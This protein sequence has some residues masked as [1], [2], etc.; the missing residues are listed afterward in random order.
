MLAKLKGHILEIVTIIYA[1]ALPYL[2]AKFG[3][4]HTTNSMHGIQAMCL[5]LLAALWHKGVIQA[6]VEA[7]LSGPPGKD[8][9]NTSSFTSTSTSK[10]A[11]PATK[12][13]GFLLP[14]VALLGLGS[15]GGC[16]S[17]TP[18]TI[19]TDVTVG[20]SVALQGWAIAEPDKALSLNSDMTTIATVINGTI[21][22]GF[23]AGAKAGTL[24]N[25]S[26]NQAL[27]LLNNKIV[28]TKSGP[29]IVAEIKLALTLST[30]LLG[31]VNSPLATMSAQSKADLIAFFSGVSQAAVAFTGNQALAPPV[32][33]VAAPTTSPAPV[34]APAAPK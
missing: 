8:T 21:L 28:G 34:I 26:V 20:L 19:Q 10:D 1:T 15:M 32:D 14:L 25:N 6:K 13:P 29:K 17:L 5:T 24:V 16:T 30:G 9:T 11:Q 27:L 23:F 12:V 18:T 7:L 3:L 31:N 33:P 4:Q 2:N 22:P